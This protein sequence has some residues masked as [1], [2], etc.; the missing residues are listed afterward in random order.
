MTIRWGRDLQI[1]ILEG[2]DYRSP[3]NMPDGPGKS[4]L[5]REQKAWLFKTLQDSDAK[6][7][8]ICS[9]TPIV[10]PDRKN[11]KDNHANEI[12]AHEGNEIRQK[13][14]AIPGVIVFCGDRHW[15]YASVDEKT[16]LWEFGCGPGS[17]KHQLGW[18]AGDER[19]VHRFLRVKGGFLSGE[20]TYRGKKK[21]S[22]LVIR[23]RS[24]TGEKVSEFEFPTQP[25]PADSSDSTAPSPRKDQPNPPA[26]LE[27]SADDKA[28]EAGKAN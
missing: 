9:P 28:N 4:I 23:H 25:T 14:S 13:V 11:K 2:R 24:V 7:K 18:K 6:F 17:E 1:W 20:L 21:E 10:G 26:K 12:F 8:L 16:N 22:K 3:N 19:P 5:G 15:Q 27:R